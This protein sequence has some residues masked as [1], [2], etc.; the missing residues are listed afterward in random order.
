M[1]GQPLE[2]DDIEP[3]TR[4][5]AEIGR[6]IT[7]VDF[8]AAIDLLRTVTRVVAG[9]WDDHDLLLT[10]TI[11]EPPPPLGSFKGPGNSRATELVPFTLP[12]NVTGQPAI[13]LP[14]HW[15]DAGLPIG[16]QLV[17]AYGRED[18][19]LRVAAQLEAAQPWVQRRPP[20][21]A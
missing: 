12:F 10:P 8:Q 13:S 11:T 17:A 19:L 9:W 21:S 3:E 1:V 4:Q 2:A 20:V 15:N 7:G 6:T 14:L 18:V 5:L 16:V